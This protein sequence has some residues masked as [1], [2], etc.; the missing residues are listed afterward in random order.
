MRQNITSVPYG[1]QAL[2]LRIYAFSKL[3]FRFVEA[4]AL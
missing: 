4:A 3:N 2:P 1:L